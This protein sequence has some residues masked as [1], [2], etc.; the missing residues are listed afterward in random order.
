MIELYWVWAVVAL[1]CFIIEISAGAQFFFLL[2]GAASMITATVV[3]LLPDISLLQSGVVFS[4]LSATIL[5]LFR[6]SFQFDHKQDQH[7]V[8]NSLAQLYHKQG[9]VLRSEGGQ[10][11]VM[12]DKNLWSAETR[13]K[14][15]LKEGSM[16]KVVGHKGMV[17]IIE[18]V[19]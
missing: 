16:I 6:A 10:H 3:L 9:S 15:Q 4:V 18:A 17:L 2:L 12:I 5:F 13:D 8:N 19:K 1:S 7:D 11:T 14:K